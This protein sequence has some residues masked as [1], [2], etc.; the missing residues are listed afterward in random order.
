[1]KY[2]HKKMR[3]IESRH[4]KKAYVTLEMSVVMGLYLTITG[5]MMGWGLQLY[6]LGTEHAHSHVETD[7][8]DSICTKK[9]QMEII[10]NIKEN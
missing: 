9:R 3:Y 4:K 5:T 10:E 1:M 2:G 6:K 8:V 7:S